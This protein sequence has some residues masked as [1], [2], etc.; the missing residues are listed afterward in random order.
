LRKTNDSSP[1]INSGAGIKTGEKEYKSGWVIFILMETYY[2]WK[3]NIP[4]KV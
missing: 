3:Q 2:S 4:E 1:Q